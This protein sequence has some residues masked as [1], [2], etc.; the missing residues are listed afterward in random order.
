[1]ANSVVEV[2]GLKQFID[3]LTESDMELTS[4]FAVAML[5][6]AKK[7][8]SAIRRKYSAYSIPGAGG[9]QAKLS[10]GQVWTG[11]AYVV[12]TMRKTSGPMS[13]SEPI[14]AQG[15][16]FGGL[17]MSKALLPGLHESED[18]AATETEAVLRR[19]ESMWEL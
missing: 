8:Q 7:V 17:M 14:T 12:Q 15:K 10:G 6:I 1:M 16:S 9:M 4:E 13:R 3:L 18:V 2:E 19:L 11:K 5:E